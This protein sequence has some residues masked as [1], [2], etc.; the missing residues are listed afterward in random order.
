VHALLHLDT[1]HK[2][3]WGHFELFFT[4]PVVRNVPGAE[5]DYSIKRYG[6]RP[7]SL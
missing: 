7:P 4:L 2:N 5:I 3:K 1:E 6:F